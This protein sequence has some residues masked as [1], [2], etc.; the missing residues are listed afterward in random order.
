MLGHT[1]F[2][3]LS[4]NPDLNVLGTSTNGGANLIKFNAETD[5]VRILVDH[6]SPSFIVNCIGKIKPEINEKIPGS[7]KSAL[8]VNSYF[9]FSLIKIPSDV[10]V[11]Q[12]ATDCV[13]QGLTGQY[14]E[15]SPHDPLDVYG[16]TKSLGEVVSPNFLN[17][18]C[19]IIGREKGTQKSLI[20]W[21]LS[22]PRNAKLNGF[23]NH[24]WNGITTLAFAK[25]VNGLINEGLDFSER[26]IQHIVPDD[27]VNKFVLLKKIAEVFDRKDLEIS[28]VESLQCIDRTLVTNFQENNFKLWQSAGYAGIPTIEELLFDYRSWLG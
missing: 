10:R 13:F 8:M 11:I 6:Y 5:D 25:A 24:M 27:S 23:T 18:R 14:S 16:K 2:D 4:S 7:I 17:L 21:V 12:I 28:E 19:S 15:I 20:E 26:S 1:V 22:Q 9:P 3:F